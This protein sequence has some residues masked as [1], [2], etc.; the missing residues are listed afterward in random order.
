MF[1]K[2]KKISLLDLYRQMNTTVSIILHLLGRQEILLC[3]TYD[4]TL[5]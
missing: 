2:L 3:S 1:D 4:T 5:S